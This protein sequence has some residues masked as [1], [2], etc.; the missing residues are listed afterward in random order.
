MQ[1][2]WVQRSDGTDSKTLAELDPGSGE[3]MG[4]QAD[5]Q[6]RMR[7]LG[8]GDQMLNAF[9]ANIGIDQGTLDDERLLSDLTN[10]RLGNTSL[11][12][13]MG[14]QYAQLPATMLESALAQWDHW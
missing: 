13:S 11:I 1:A 10:M 5:L 12:P 9:G 4:S 2:D 3:V 14:M 7:A 6:N 8:Y